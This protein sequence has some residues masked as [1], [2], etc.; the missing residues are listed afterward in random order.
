MAPLIGSEALASG[1]LTPYALRSRFAAIYPDVY[2]PRDAEFTALMRAQAA[3][4]WSR[5]EGVIAGRS[6]AA[7]HRAKWSTLAAPPNCSGATETTTRYPR[8]VGQRR[9]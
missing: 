3:W 9:R 5:R 1:R 6:S 8:V 2:L 4:L 7:L